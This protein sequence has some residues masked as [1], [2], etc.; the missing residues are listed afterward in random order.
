MQESLFDALEDISF[1]QLK[2]PQK[3]QKNSKI[4]NVGALSVPK[5]TK[6]FLEKLNEEANNKNSDLF[7][8]QE[9]LKIAKG[10]NLSLGL[11]FSNYIEKLNFEN[12][13]IL[14]GGRNYQLT[15]KKEF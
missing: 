7:D 6:I 3:S 13:L 14:K 9:L 12:Y 4:L 2:N 8:Y 10:L 1:N 11:D 15:K 5:Q